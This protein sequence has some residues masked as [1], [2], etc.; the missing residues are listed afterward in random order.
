MR[1]RAWILVSSLAAA[2]LPFSA[3]RTARGPLARIEGG[4]YRLGSSSEEREAG[5]RLSPPGVRA[6]GWYEAWESDPRPVELAGFW[7][8][9][10]PVT[11]E[12][13]AAFVRATGRPAPTI[14][15]EA[16]QRQGF[17][18]HPYAEVLPYRW[19]EVHPPP[20]REDHPVVLVD[21]ADAEAYC[22]WRGMRL[23]D[24]QEWEAACRGAQGRFFPWGDAWVSE[25]ARVG[26]SGTA[27]VTVRP[28][29]CTPDDVC[30]LAGNVFE[31]TRSTA[32]DGR[33][34]L[35]GCSWDDAP[36]TCRCAFRHR[37]PPGSRHI[38]IGFRCVRNDSDRASPGSAHLPQRAPNGAPR[39]RDSGHLIGHS[40]PP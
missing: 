2:C 24:Q 28:R 11:Q 37:R 35:K 10:F 20:G 33:A 29:G 3:V 16:Y 25:A 8:D 36:G 21:R 32:P 22:A 26:A 19:V 39:A 27:P 15:A 23:P 18:V 40:D 9:R 6:Q 5:Y 13:Y 14:S 34:V 38:L 30:E 7:I 12:G 17:L 31:W 4:T 1:V